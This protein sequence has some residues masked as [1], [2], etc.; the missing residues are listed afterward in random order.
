MM[1]NVDHYSGCCFTWSWPFAILV[2]MVLSCR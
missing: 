2:Q 1:M